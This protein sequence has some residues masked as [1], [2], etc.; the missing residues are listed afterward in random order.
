[1]DVLRFIRVKESGFEAAAKAL[2][3]STL[4]EN[5]KVESTVKEI[6]ARVQAEGDLALL[7]LGRKFDCPNLDDLEVTEAEW[8]AGCDAVAPA[9]R[10]LLDQAAANI[11]HF[12]EKQKRNSWLEI[13]PGKITGQMI[14]PLERVGV[15][16]PGGTA[17]YPSSVLMAA[18]PAKAAGVKEIII[19]TPAGKDGT[20]NPYG[21]YA[22]RLAGAKR[23]FK[24]GGAQ[25]IAALAFGT[26]SIPKVDK[27]VGPGNSYVNVAKKLLWGVVDID[28]LAGPSEVCVVADSGANAAYAATDMLT[29]AEH[30]TDSVAYLITDSEEFGQ[31]VLKELDERI[32]DLPRRE[33]LKQA[34]E[35]CGA[36]IVAESLEQACDLANVC[37]PEHLAL[38]VRE[39]FAWLGRIKCAGAVLMGDYSPQT[40][41]DYMAGPSHTLPTSGT[42][43]FASPLH[44]ETFLKKSS[45]IY[46]TKESLD[47]V[48]DGLIQFA[49]IEGFAAHAEAV[50]VREGGD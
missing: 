25:A 48:S 50:R 20:I 6:I 26:E 11:L 39:P 47:Q 4:Q 31:S 32:K 27:V 37:A 28:M 10:A 45:F 43:R 22:A 30:D 2:V 35:E 13:E 15:Y 18:L 23:I 24:V 7:E 3:R 29:Q 8:Q 16:V 41:G 14:N 19:T 36:I 46:Y 33:I 5:P 40:L 44:T 34:L 17:I 12:H 49:G 9:D 1:M 21:L 42:A 38:M